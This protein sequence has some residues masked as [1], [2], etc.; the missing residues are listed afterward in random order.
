MMTKEEKAEAICRR[1]VA[2]GYTKQK[3]VRMYG[4]EFEL[5][6][7]PFVDEDSFAVHAVSTRSGRT[8]QLHIPLSV[9]RSVTRRVEGEHA[10]AA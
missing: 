7:N 8:R 1:L 5:T 4:E 9:V 10:D 3:R 6:S 2:L